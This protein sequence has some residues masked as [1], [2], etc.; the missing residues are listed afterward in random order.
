MAKKAA[1]KKAPAKKKRPYGYGMDGVEETGEFQDAGGRNCIIELKPSPGDPILKFGITDDV[2]FQVMRPGIMGW[3]DLELPKGEG[4]HVV[5]LAYMY[6]SQPQVKKLL[7]MLK[8]FA[9]TGNV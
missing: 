6:L 3:H 8:K 1:V 2:L 7:P 5:Q 4:V 9:K